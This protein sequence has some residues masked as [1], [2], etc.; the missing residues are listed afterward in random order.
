MASY[1]ILFKR[2]AEKELRKISS[3]DLRKILNKIRSLPKTPR[4]VAAQML[5]GDHRYYRIRQGDYRVIYEVDDAAKE[6]CVIK[7]GHRRDIYR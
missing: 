1:K 7:V 5:R 4:P 3:V 6:I 2:S